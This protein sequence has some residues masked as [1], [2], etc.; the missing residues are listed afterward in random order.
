L[1]NKIEKL[2]SQYKIN[3]SIYYKN[4]KNDK[5][6]MFNEN[7]KLP[8]ASLIKLFIMY[9]AFRKVEEGVISLEN[10]LSVE[11]KD[12]VEF[13]VVE[14]LSI[15]KYTL[16]DLITLMIIQSDNTAT[17]IL[18]NYLG[19]NSINDTIKELSM[20]KTCLNRKMM[21]FYAREN[22]IDNWT[23]AQNVG[24]LLCKIYKDEFVNSENKKKIFEVMKRQIFTQMIPRYLD[25]SYEVLNKTGDLPNINHDA[26]IILHSKGDSVLVI[27][28]TDCQD[29][30]KA[31]EF[32]GKAAKFI[33]EEKV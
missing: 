5:E 27:M 2:M 18:I 30:Y 7:K 33:L 31:Q 32:I 16:R 3:C 25:E 24:E 6:F 22:N 23:T 12:R 17:N 8:S 26:A 29:K 15:D 4:L 14:S 1:K 13:S 10:Q 9:H 21:D 11:I 28:T 20:N 19:I